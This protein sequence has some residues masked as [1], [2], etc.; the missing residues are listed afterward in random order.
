MFVPAYGIHDLIFETLMGTKC[1]NM[2]HILEQENWMVEPCS[3]LSIE[4]H[5]Q[6]LIQMDHSFMHSS[7]HSF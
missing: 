2:I 5:M 6:I 4:K 3:I 1:Q 7:V